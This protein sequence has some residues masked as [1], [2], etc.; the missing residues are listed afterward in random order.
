MQFLFQF[1]ASLLV[2][3][4]NNQVTDCLLTRDFCTNGSPKSYCCVPQLNHLFMFKNIMEIVTFSSSLSWTICHVPLKSFV[5]MLHVY[6][7]LMMMV[8]IWS[9]RR[10]NVLLSVQWI[11]FWLY[12]YIERFYFGRWSFFHFC[13]SSHRTFAYKYMYIHIH[14]LI[15][16]YIL[17]LNTNIYIIY[18]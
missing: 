11:W 6:K 14:R 17:Y 3:W 12:F 10:R 9:L 5:C 4:K 1:T 2:S 18:T 13:F 8:V 16:I 15:Y 7:I